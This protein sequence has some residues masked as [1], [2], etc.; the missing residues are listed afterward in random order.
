[1]WKDPIVEETRR[2]RREL[3]Q[4]F[5]NDPKAIFAHVRKKQSVTKRQVVSRAPRSTRQQKDIR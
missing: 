1:M 2:L 5:N 4:E 3:A